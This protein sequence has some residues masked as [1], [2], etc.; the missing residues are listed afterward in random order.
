MNALLAKCLAC[1][2]KDKIPVHWEGFHVLTWCHCTTTRLQ[3]YVNSV[4][5]LT[6]EQKQELLRLREEK[7]DIERVCVCMMAVRMLVAILQHAKHGRS[8]TCYVP[9]LRRGNTA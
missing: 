4:E 8:P 2:L 5:S 1:V 9:E 3:D 6:N 7:R